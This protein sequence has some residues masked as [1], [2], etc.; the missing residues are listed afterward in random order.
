M[1]FQGQ[2]L[3]I[4]QVRFGTICSKWKLA[5]RHKM[6]CHIVKKQFV[7]GKFTDLLYYSRKMG[8]GGDRLRFSHYLGWLLH[9]KAVYQNIYFIQRNRLSEL[10]NDLVRLLDFILF[11][12]FMGPNTLKIQENCQPG[13]LF[14][15]IWKLANK[16]KKTWTKNR[17]NVIYISTYIMSSFTGQLGLVRIY[18]G[19]SRLSK[20]TGKSGP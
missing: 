10:L 17:A 3:K 5:K 12:G 19:I 2:W 1:T 13:C 7:V 20:I 4:A 9:V 16:H 18:T 15:N 6:A 8:S 14:W 11:P